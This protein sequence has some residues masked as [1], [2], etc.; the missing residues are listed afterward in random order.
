MNTDY[1]QEKYPLQRVAENPVRNGPGI[2]WLL[3]KQIET[4]SLLKAILKELKKDTDE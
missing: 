1:L 2:V 4:N 3:A